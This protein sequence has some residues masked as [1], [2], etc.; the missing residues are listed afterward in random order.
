[1]LQKYNG[2][3]IGAGSYGIE[4]FSIKNSDGEFIA[5][6]QLEQWRGVF[7]ISHFWIKEGYRNIGIEERLI[8]CID[9]AVEAWNIRRIY[10]LDTAIEPKQLHLLEKY[11]YTNLSRNDNYIYLSKDCI[12]KSLENSKIEARLEVLN[13]R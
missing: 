13:S 5:G 12:N 9:S 4:I 8:S 10:A 2:T 11:G 6:I 3:F 1:V 7:G